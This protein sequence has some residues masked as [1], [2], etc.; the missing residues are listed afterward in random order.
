MT[1]GLSQWDQVRGIQYGDVRHKRFNP[2]YLSYG[3]VCFKYFYKIKF[4]IFL[5][6]RSV[7]VRH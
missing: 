4:W 1:F 7:R 3:V 6:F 5:E 2:T